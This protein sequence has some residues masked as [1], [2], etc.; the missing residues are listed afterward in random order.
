MQSF[1]PHAMAN[2]VIQQSPR[3]YPDFVDYLTES[4][5]ERID[6][7]TSGKSYRNKLSIIGQTLAASLRL[8]RHIPR[9]RHVRVIVAFGHFVYV[10]RLLALL[11]IINYDESFCFAFFVHSPSWFP[12]FRLLARLDTENDRY[13]I[14]SRTEMDLYAYELGI[15]RRRMRFLPYGDW[16]TK[17]QIAQLELQTL[18]DGFPNDYYF[19][20]GYSNR[21]Y[22]SLVEAFRHIPQKLVIVCSSLNRELDDVILPSNV[23]VLRDLPSAQFEGYIR[24]SKACLLP[25]KHDTGA[26]GQ[27]V[28]VRHMRNAKLTIATDA[29]SIR[30]YIELGRSGYLIHSWHAE[31]KSVIHE[32]ESNPV[33]FTSMGQAAYDAYRNSFSRERVADLCTRILAAA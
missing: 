4:G 21:D 23:T 19:A 17:V 6:L 13:L 3:E 5:F 30:E 12:L 16:Q 15:D 2:I 7:G 25:L 24:H 14:F 11:R 20:G 31:L 9:L 18:N 22:L 10:L 28:I 26:S 29:G 8:L 32:L 1:A 27:S 33:L